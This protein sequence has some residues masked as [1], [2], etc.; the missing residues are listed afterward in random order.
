MSTIKVR[1]LDISKVEDSINNSGSKRQ[2]E[3]YVF[4]MFKLLK[5]YM[6]IYIII[7]VIDYEKMLKLL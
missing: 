2:I 3:I 4:F 6:E 7:L 5:Y 1:T